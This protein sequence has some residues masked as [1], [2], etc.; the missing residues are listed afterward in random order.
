MKW[1][2]F[3]AIQSFRYVVLSVEAASLRTLFICGAL[4]RRRPE[5]VPGTLKRFTTLEIVDMSTL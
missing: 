3:L 5:T 1:S 2:M 4:E